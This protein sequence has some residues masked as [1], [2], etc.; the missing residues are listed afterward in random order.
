MRAQLARV[1]EIAGYPGIGGGAELL[2]NQAD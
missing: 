1:K 2:V